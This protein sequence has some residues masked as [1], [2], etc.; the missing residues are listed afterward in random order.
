MMIS[1]WDVTCAYDDVTCA[2]DDVTCAYD[3]VTCA[4]HD[5]TCAYDDV[6]CAYDDVTCAVMTFLLVALFDCSGCLIGLSRKAGIIG[7]SLLLVT[8]NIEHIYDES[9]LLIYN[10]IYD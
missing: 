9:L 4:Y 3:D 7:T 2:Y 1:A 10:Y 8:S 6:T 5:V